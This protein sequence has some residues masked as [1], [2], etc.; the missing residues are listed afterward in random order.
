[1]SSQATVMSNGESS[2][3]ER[4]D[5]YFLNSS[6]DIEPV[7]ENLR[8]LESIFVEQLANAHPN[9]QRNLEEMLQMNQQQQGNRA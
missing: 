9:V 8:A 4:R 5:D 2:S 6:R 1:M 3:I 7:V